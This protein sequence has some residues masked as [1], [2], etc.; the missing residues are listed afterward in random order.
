MWFLSLFN[1]SFVVAFNF[2]WLSD[3]YTCGLSDVREQ[4]GPGISDIVNQL[5]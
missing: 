5:Y 4:L 2:S 3:Y 1:E